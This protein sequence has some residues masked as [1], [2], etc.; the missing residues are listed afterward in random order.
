MEGLKAHGLVFLLTLVTAIVIMCLA[1][2]PLQIAMIVIGAKYKDECPVE[3]MIPIYLIVAGS[4]AL[5]SNC[6]TCGI[7]YKQRGNQEEQSVNPLQIVVQFF[8][9]AWFICGNVWIYKN[10][11]PN[12]TDPES[13]DYC[14]KTLYLFAFWVTN[15]YY[16]IFGLVL[17]CVCLAGTCAGSMFRRE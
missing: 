12:Y 9:F 8:L 14:H 17:T 5:F 6:C 2:F 11:E 7:T 1:T 10:Y 13:P 4:A 16:I 15:S 3:D